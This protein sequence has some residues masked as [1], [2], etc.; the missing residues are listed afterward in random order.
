[1]S[2]VT[3]HFKLQGSSSHDLLKMLNIGLTVDILAEEHDVD[4][5]KS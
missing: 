2:Y 3:V 1:M 4:P 5:A